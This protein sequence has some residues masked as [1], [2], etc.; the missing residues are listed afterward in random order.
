MKKI[1]V[2]FSDG[3]VWEIPASVVAESRAKYY[4]E[5]EPGCYEEEYDITIKDGMEM[6]DWAENNMN[7]SDV[8]SKAK[9]IQTKSADYED[10]WTNAD[11]EIK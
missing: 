5:R 2:T 6:M 7:W 8:R 9:K 4:E 11:K 1:T 10:E 3:T